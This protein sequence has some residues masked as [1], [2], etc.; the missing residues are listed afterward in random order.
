[1]ER[2][3]E[4]EREK[5]ENRE[6]GERQQARAGVGRRV[7]ELEGRGGREVMDEQE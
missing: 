7:R 3:K 5:E 4:K 1:M 2:R 6:G